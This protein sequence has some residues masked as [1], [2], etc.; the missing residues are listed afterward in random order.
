MAFL[1]FVS[2]KNKIGEKIRSIRNN[3]GLSQANVA[4]ELNITPGAY[5]K[6]DRGETDAP[7]SRLLQIA[8]ILEVHISAFFEGAP[9][10]K[11]NKNPNYGYASKTDVEN[12]SLLVHSLIKEV[13]KLRSEL[14]KV[15][16]KKK[17]KTK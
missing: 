3:K 4:H 8:Q 9:L 15:A 12:L 17:T 11:E 7:T 1:K 14:P 13:E 2:V 10:I 16:P 5:A 6:I